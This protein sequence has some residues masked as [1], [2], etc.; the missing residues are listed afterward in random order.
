M[1]APTFVLHRMPQIVVT[2]AYATRRKAKRIAYCAMVWL[3][4]CVTRLALV[5]ATVRLILR[6]IPLV[7]P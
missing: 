6:L 2:G 1:S 5:V 3:V 4:P 7:T